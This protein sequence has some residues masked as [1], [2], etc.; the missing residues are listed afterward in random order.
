ML[1]GLPRSTSEIKEKAKDDARKAA[2]GASAISLLR[3]ARTQSLSAQECEMA[4]DLT[5][6]LNAYITAVTLAHMLTETAEYR[7]ESLPGKKGVL[8]REFM[9]F[10]QVSRFALGPGCF[11]LRGACGGSYWGVCLT[12]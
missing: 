5:G 10:S 12:A 1:N 6:A 8:F 9:E 7:A 3:T 2:R 4:G 11:S